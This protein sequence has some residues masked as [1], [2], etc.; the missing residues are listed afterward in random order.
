MFKESLLLFLT[1]SIVHSQINLSKDFPSINLPTI[2][3]PSIPDVFNYNSQTNPSG[4]KF[5]CGW[6]TI[7]VS[8]SSTLNVNPDIAVI[9]IALSENGASTNAAISK[10]S[11]KIP[12]VLDRLTKNGL[13]SSNWQTTSLNVYPNSSY[14]NG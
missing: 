8:G 7:S 3:P 13:N 1:L 14:V 2:T 10:L 4:C 5:D 6:N 11:K 12:I 9:N